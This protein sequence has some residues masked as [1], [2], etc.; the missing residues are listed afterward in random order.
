MA[1]ADTNWNDNYPGIII[2]NDAS[3]NPTFVLTV[4]EQLDKIA[5]Q[6]VGRLMLR[7]I[8]DRAI[9]QP[10]G[11]KVCIQR[12]A[13]TVD[14]KNDLPGKRWH[15]TNVTKGSKMNLATNGGGGTT[16]A[17]Y[18]N[19]NVYVTPDGTRPPYIGLAHE[20]IHAHHNLHGTSLNVVHDDEHKVVGMGEYATAPITEN[21]IRAEHQVA[22]RT[23]YVGV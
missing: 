3:K 7:E 20:M 6:P 17:I 21:K 1:N 16:S 18:Y 4:K 19:P 13:N 11:Y 23:S 5:S 14:L 15:G 9:A 22:D 10:F 12:T 2:R 8:A